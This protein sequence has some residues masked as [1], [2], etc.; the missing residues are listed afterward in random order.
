MYRLDEQEILQQYDREMEDREEKSGRTKDGSKGEPYS[1]PE[2]T[3]YYLKEIRKYQLLS[4]EEEQEIGRQALQGDKRAKARM[5][6]SNLRLV[7]AIAKKYINRGLPFPDLIEEGN[8]GLM[9]AVEKFQPAKGFKFSTYATW[10][11]RQAIERALANQTRTIRLPVHVSENFIR[12]TRTVRRL[13]QELMREPRPGEIAQR[14]RI[15]VEKVRILSQVARETLS[16][17]VTVGDQEDNAL[18]D[19]I[20]DES[21]ASPLAALSEQNNRRYLRALLGRLNT[22]ERGIIERRFGLRNNV[23]ETLN[24]IGKKYGL[25]RERVRQIEARALNK[26]KL[27]TQEDGY[28]EE[29]AGL[30]H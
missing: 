28:G 5:I 22:N 18:K 9:R 23:P 17:D 21:T 26:L 20:A 3:R 14:M 12:Y 19:M 11:I 1:E 6:E 25:T 30:I 4:F 24:D 16:L 15:P 7:V 13:T 8:L 2:S 27:F 29:L 10:W